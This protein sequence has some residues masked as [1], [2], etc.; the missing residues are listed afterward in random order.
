MVM[1][2]LLQPL[3]AERTQSLEMKDRYSWSMTVGNKKSGVLS[4]NAQ[5]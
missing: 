1:G 2:I 5:I 4:I 3:P